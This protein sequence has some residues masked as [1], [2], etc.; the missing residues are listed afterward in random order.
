M[1]PQIFQYVHPHL[2]STLHT[3]RILRG[4][5]QLLDLDSV[6]DLFTVFVMVFW[7]NH[8]QMKDTH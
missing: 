4:T 1:I 5:E 7:G 3:I 2:L 8:S 6:T